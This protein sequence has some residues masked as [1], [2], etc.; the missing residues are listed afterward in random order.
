MKVATHSDEYPAR[1]IEII[2]PALW[3]SGQERVEFKTQARFFFLIM[4]GEWK[5]AYLRE[6]VPSSW[7]RL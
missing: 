6:T 7:L 1:A 2:N 3:Q 4:L 5:W